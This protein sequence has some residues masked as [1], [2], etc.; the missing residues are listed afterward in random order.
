[1]VDCAATTD[2]DL[3]SSLYTIA[4]WS[5]RVTHYQYDRPLPH[6]GGTDA[7]SFY[8]DQI[9]ISASAPGTTGAA[10][11]NPAYPALYA[12]TLNT[13]K[14]VAHVRP[15]FYDEA[16]AVTASGPHAGHLVKLGLTDPDSNEVV[17]WSAPRF[18][19]TSC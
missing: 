5:G 7:I 6:H 4:P 11:P 15:V 19:G 16:R 17:P 12:V 14:H 8:R 18:G 9:M 13:A 1:V 10:A 3:H 2:E